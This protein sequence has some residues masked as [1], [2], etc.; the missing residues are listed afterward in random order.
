MSSL[1]LLLVVVIDVVSIVAVDGVTPVL[2][3]EVGIDE[4][5]TTTSS[6]S[7]LS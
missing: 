2:L 7:P 1:M 5:P 3:V 6:Q 4:Q